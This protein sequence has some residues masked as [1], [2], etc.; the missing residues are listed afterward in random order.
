MTA[1]RKLIILFSIFSI[2]S[3]YGE[4]NIDTSFDLKDISVSN[5]PI[6]DGSDSTSPLRY[7]LM[8]KLLGFDYEWQSSPF[9]QNPEEA[10]EQKRDEKEGFGIVFKL[11]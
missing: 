5:F 11:Y 4:D 2:F 1:K 7:I 9:I 8:C 3:C 6:I 10:I